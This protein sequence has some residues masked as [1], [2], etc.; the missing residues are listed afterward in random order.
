M[1]KANDMT[2]AQKWK[3]GSINTPTRARSHISVVGSNW[4]KFVCNNEEFEGQGE[5][6]RPQIL[7]EHMKTVSN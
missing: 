1:S 4:E 6:F 5:V 7:T 2:K 3:C